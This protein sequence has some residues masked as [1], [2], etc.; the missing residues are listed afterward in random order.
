MRDICIA[1][2]IHPLNRGG[3]NRVVRILHSSFEALE[4]RTLLTAVLSYHN[5]LQSTGVNSTETLLTPATVNI[6]QFHKQFSVP[7]DGQVYGQPLYDPAVNITTGSQPGVHNTVFI[8]T[9]HDSL[10]AIDTNGG[11]IL[12]HD[13]FIYNAAGNPNP[14]NPAIPAGVTTM[15]S[16]DTGSSDINPEI[17]ITSTPVIDP[18]TGMLF[19]TAKTKQ[20]DA[21]GFTHYVYTLYKINIHN[22]VIAASTVMGDTINSGGTYYYRVTSTGSGTD[23]YVNGTGDGSITSQ[24][25]IDGQA[26]GNWGGQS[27]VYFNAQRQMNRPGLV[28]ANGSIY[29]SFASHGDNGPYHGWVLRYDPATLTLTGA[30]NTTP[31]GGLGGIW[32]GGGITSVDAQGNLYCETGNG[33]FNTNSSN[34]PGGQYFP[35]DHD[36]GDCFIKISADTTHN[37]ASNQN[38]NGWGMQITDYFSPYNNATLNAGD[39]DLGSGAPVVLPDAVGST[40]HPHLLIGDGKEGK[41]YLIDRDHMGG[42]SST[43][44]NVV[45]TQSNTATSGINGSL[46]TP[47]FFLN[48]AGGTSGSLYYFPGYGGD[49][50]AFSVSN[51][52]FSANYTSH[53]TD[54]S[55]FSSLDGTPS[56]SANGTSNG[57]VWVVDRGTNT[58]RAYNALNLSTELWDSNAAPNGRDTL[59]AATKFSVPTVADGIVMVGTLNSLVIFGPPVAPTSPPAAPSNLIATSP[60]YQT[61]NLSWNDNSNNEDEFLI[62][63]SPDGSTGWT[64]IG[65]S[66]ANVASY[67]DNTTAGST[68]YYYRVR[69]FNSYVGGSYSAYTNIVSIKTPAPPPIGTGDGLAAAFYLDTSSGGGHLQGTP[70]LTRTDPTIDFNW[71]GASPGP[72]IGGTDF[73]AKWTGSFRAANTETYSFNVTAD[74][75]V[76]L[77]IDGVL[78][79]NGWVDQ[80]PTLYTYS[81]ALTAGQTHT[82]EMDYYQNQGGSVAQFHWSSTGATPVA[83]TAVP[84]LNGGAAGQ[85][86]NDTPAGAYTH[87]QG[88][89]VLTRVD[90]FIDSTTQW[91]N[92]APDPVVGN[93]NFSVKWTGRVQAQFTDTY[94]FYTQ[95]DDGVS[96]SVNGQQIINDWTYHGQTL[97]TG[98]IALVAGQ[99]YSI[100][101]DFFQ[102]GGPDYCQLLW[103]STATPQE[104]IPQTQLYSGVAPAAPSNLAAVAASGTQFNLSWNE[105]SKIETGFDLER[106]TGT[107]GTFAPVPADPLPPNTTSYM[108]SGLTPGI[109][110]TYEVRALNF[111]ANSAYTPPLQVTAPTPPNK[112]TN[113]HV[114]S[115]STTQVSIAWTDNSNNED[116]FRILRS[117]PGS[118][119]FQIA[120]LPPNTTA[121]TDNGLGGAGLT[122][123][124]E[125][126]YHVQAY[127]IAGYNDFT[128]TDTA[129]LTLPP[130]GPTAAPGNGQIALNWTAPSYNAANSTSLTFNVYRGTTAGGEAPTAVATGLTSP[131]FTDTSLVIGQTY[132]YK[133]TAVE[134]GGE[135]ARSTEISALALPVGFV[136]GSGASVT[137]TGPGASQTLEVTA[138]SV[139]VGADVAASLPGLT[140]KVDSG[141]S[142]RLTAT[143]HLGNFVLTGGTASLAPAAGIALFSNGLSIGAGSSLDLADD[144]LVLSYAAPSPIDVVRQSILAGQLTTS[145]SQVSGHAVTLAQLDNSKIHQTTWG[146]LTISDGTNFDQI[147]VKRAYVGDTNLDGVVDQR[148]YLN[149]LANMGHNGAQWL[150]GDLDHS[151]IVTVDDLAAV[152]ANLG[153]GTGGSNGPALPDVQAGSAIAAMPLPSY[154]ALSVRTGSPISGAVLWPTRLSPS[155]KSGSSTDALFAMPVRPNAPRCSTCRNQPASSAPR[156]TT[157]GSFSHWLRRSS[158]PPMPVQPQ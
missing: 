71:N 54:A 32:Q 41:I 65:A 91:P 118:D 140:L 139:T 99:Q 85:Y 33:S 36:Y 1:E 5:D 156:P 115:N 4:P 30:L 61:V 67:S 155:R 144:A 108:D 131:T 102:G 90:P 57:I 29:V 15:P 125:Y 138:G 13:S 42:F 124:T 14:L 62:E 28:L 80:A 11:S 34:F 111:A 132:Y 59:G 3:R 70:A 103:S 113:A 43:T 117:A 47:G 101:L 89:P 75:G 18:S 119:F 120:L 58:L 100:E 45:E 147:L 17:G 72:G 158:R 87:L 96:L 12:W 22:G 21:A 154:D 110:Y 141:A 78:V 98:T 134:V 68:T 104:L 86:F 114:T 23:P 46:N 137:G 136:P 40:I 133:V 130:T 25:A 107:G 92:Y 135:S 49:G 112:P 38:P 151:G 51:G 145:V 152:S 9:Q 53:T 31:N 106:M 109:T 24:A 55:S 66:S 88:T 26:T 10:Y 60:N 77:Y 39:T 6:N 121:Y 153:A 37:T 48:G 129:T 16:G 35:A 50:R 64:Q 84:I 27:R 81:K 44:D 8:T 82:F 63:R 79:I 74:D 83:D 94:T 149:I 127:N 76:E 20:I 143:Q 122:P 116:G 2:R 150:D 52:T 19:L 97:D 146:G 126:E 56:I 95:S 157:H 123:G 73:S 148:D 142:A 93:T 105:G 69:A 128:G 7:V